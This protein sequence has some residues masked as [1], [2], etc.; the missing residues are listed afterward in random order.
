MS[1]SY[2]EDCLDRKRVREGITE[3]R[4]ANGKRKKAKP[5]VVQYRYREGSGIAKL[6]P[7]STSWSKH[8]QYATVDI[9]NEVI[10][11]Q[12]KKHPDN[13]FRIKPKDGA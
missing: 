3:P 9:A 4:P 2:R 11:K 1:Q 12:T 8:G 10:E 7:R 6:F 13:E 5:V